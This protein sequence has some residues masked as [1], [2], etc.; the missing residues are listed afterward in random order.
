MLHPGVVSHSY[1]NA[2]LNRTWR[3]S[4]ERDEW[5]TWVILGARKHWPL[6]L[7]P[8]KPS[9]CGVGYCSAL[10]GA[11]QSLNAAQM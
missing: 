5:S 7:Q 9:R 3:F 4:A 10:L 8:G 2:C 11:L 1:N 6:S